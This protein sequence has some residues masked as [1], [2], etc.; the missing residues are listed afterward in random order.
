M[1]PRKSLEESMDNADR[2]ISRGVINER[3]LIPLNTVAIIVVNAI[4]LAGMYFSLRQQ[5]S[6]LAR[7]RWTGTMQ[8]KWQ[9][10]VAKSNGYKWET[11]DVREVQKS[12]KDN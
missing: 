5:I 2:V 6:D 4:M 10:Q 7:D 3:T 1:S 9:S 12:L 8:D 11:A